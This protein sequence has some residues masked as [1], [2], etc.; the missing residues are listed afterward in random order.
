MP[1]KFS[2]LILDGKWMKK[3]TPAGNFLVL[4]FVLPGAVG[5]RRHLSDGLGFRIYDSETKMKNEKLR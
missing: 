3:L 5:Y 2:A 4:F 1:G